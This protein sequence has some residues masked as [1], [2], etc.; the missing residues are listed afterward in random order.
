MKTENAL[1]KPANFESLTFDDLL[2]FDAGRAYVAQQL[3]GEVTPVESFKSDRPM[4]ESCGYDVFEDG[5]L[6]LHSNSQDEVWP[7]AVDFSRQMQF[8]GLYW[9]DFDGRSGLLIDRM[10]KDLLIHLFCDEDDAREFFEQAGGWS[11]VAEGVFPHVSGVI[12]NV[13]AEI[14]KQAVNDARGHQEEF[15]GQPLIGDWDTAA[16]SEAMRELRIPDELREPA[17]AHYTK[18]LH[19]TINAMRGR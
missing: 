16:C 5:S 11:N 18:V 12:E 6:W 17:A 3:G 10:D 15:P 13:R 9:E 19:Q 1:R 4:A 14:G 7:D 2:A 8:D